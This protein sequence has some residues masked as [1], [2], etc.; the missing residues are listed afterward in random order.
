L[1]ELYWGPESWFAHRTPKPD[2]TLYSEEEAAIL[3]SH[4]PEY[5][6]IE[7]ESKENGTWLQ[8]PDGSTW[9]GDPRSWVMM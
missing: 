1:D 7:K 9:E 4:V 2:G 6:K 8:M 3:A 5:K